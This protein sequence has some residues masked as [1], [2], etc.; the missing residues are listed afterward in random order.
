MSVADRQAARE[1]VFQSLGFVT[2]LRPKE[3]FVTD[4]AS[5]TLWIEKLKAG[6][7]DAAQR[8]WERYYSQLL[9]LARRRLEG[10]SKRVSDEEDV[11]LSAFQ[12]FWQ[13]AVAGRFPRLENRDDLWQLLVMHTARKAIAQRRY[14]QRQ[15]RHGTV[16]DAMLHE[17]VGNEPAP[18]FAAAVVDEF[19]QLMNRL[20]DETLCA[21]ALK[22]LEG[23]TNREIAE[24]V[25]CSLRS[26]E[27]K[28]AV[29]RGFWSETDQE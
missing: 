9:T 19:Q 10:L 5:V 14:A 8:I 20:G 2:L 13:A 28:L 18:D 25:G 27:R 17:V 29:I 26:V 21:I 11:A 12:S 22:K 7:P 16:S 24:Q 23:W 6:E 3:N 15:K 1:D 4:S